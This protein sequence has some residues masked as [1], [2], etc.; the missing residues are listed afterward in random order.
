MSYKDE[1]LD[2]K[3]RVKHIVGKPRVGLWFRE[4]KIVKFDHSRH[5][6]RS[7]VMFN[8]LLRIR[9]YINRLAEKQ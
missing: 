9:Q 6:E 5:R 7:G 2:R 1:L 3:Y 4:G 8:K